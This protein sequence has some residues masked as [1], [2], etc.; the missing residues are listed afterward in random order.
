MYGP[1]TQ[2]PENSLHDHLP[3]PTPTSTPV[4]PKITS[5]YGKFQ[6]K[7]HENAEKKEREHGE[8]GGIGKEKE[9]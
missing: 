4:L 7:F 9:G 2:Q 3:K 8:A 1:C 5:Y 6:L